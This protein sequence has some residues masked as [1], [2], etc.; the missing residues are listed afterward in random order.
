MPGLLEIRDDLRTRAV[1]GRLTVDLFV[2]VAGEVRVRRYQLL[3]LL[4]GEGRGRGRG[5]HA[6]RGEREQSGGGDGDEAVHQTSFLV[7][8]IFFAAVSCL[9]A[10]VSMI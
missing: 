8:M 2:E 5:R 3:V 1:E 10:G 6:R 7:S 9:S 4:R